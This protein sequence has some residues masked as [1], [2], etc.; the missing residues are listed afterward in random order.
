MT[1]NFYDT[2]ARVL[3]KEGRTDDAIVAFQQGDS[4][5]PS[6]LNVLIG[7]ASTYAK[8]N[9]MD[10]AARYLNRIDPLL[11]TNGPISPDL[12]SELDGARQLVIKA[13]GHSS[14]AGVDLQSAIH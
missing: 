11:A 13:S 5:Q 7:L 12:K 1:S 9:Q 6:N 8:T 10:L 2:L 4:L 14:A 3:L